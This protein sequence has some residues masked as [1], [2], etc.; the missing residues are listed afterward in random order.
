MCRLSGGQ[1]SVKPKCPRQVRRI[2]Q[3]ILLIRD[4]SKL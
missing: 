2:R 1:T 4:Q 3:A